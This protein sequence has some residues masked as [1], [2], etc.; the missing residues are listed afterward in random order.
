MAQ[1]LAFDRL[2]SDGRAANWHE[3]HDFFGHVA[4]GD[5][6]WYSFI[7]PHHSRDDNS[8]NQHPG[9]NQEPSGGRSDFHRGELLVRSIYEALR[10]NERLFQET[11]LVIT[12]D[13]HGGLFDHAEPPKARHP[14]PLRP[15]FSRLEFTRRVVAWLVENRYSPFDFRRLGVRVPAIVISPWIAPRTVDRDRVY[16]HTSII[17]TLRLLFAPDEKPLT[18]RDKAAN[19]FY[20][21][22]RHTTV[23]RTMP[24][25]PPP[26]P[27]EPSVESGAGDRAPP[28]PAETAPRA[29]QADTLSE[30][31]SALEQQLR[32]L[33]ALGLAARG[34]RPAIDEIDVTD[35][36]VDFA[37]DERARTRVT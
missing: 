25:S 6:P 10:R 2:W 33:T 28:R 14:T 32:E 24:Q 8:N 11:M 26:A 22:V 5:L 34:E 3:M 35:R 31:L 4:A 13:E 30:Q 36:F 9:N 29:T 1:T 15:K 19:P 27:P 21:L 20:E 23:A 37:R 18:A 17:A 16:D 7:E 12:Y